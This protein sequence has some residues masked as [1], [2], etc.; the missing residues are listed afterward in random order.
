M[1]EI[2]EILSDAGHPLT[3]ENGNLVSGALKELVAEC[4]ALRKDA[5]RYRWLRDG[6]ELE[7]FKSAWLIK[8]DIYGFTSI[9]MDLAIDAAMGEKQ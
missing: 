6:T 4:E 3:N 5:E 2:K 1:K 8:N 9:A 7:P